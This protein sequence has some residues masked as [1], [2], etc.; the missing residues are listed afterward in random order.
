MNEESYPKNFIE[1]LD[2][3]K[4]EESCRKYLFEL[5]WKEGFH[6]PKCNNDT[7]WLTAQNLIHCK[8]CGHQ[9]SLTSGTIFHGTRKPLLL[10][11]HVMW[12]VV[13]QKTG[14]SA[15]NMTDLWGLE[16]IGQRGLGCKNYA[17]RWLG[18]AG[19]GCPGLLRL[20]KPSLEGWNPLQEIQE[21]AKRPK[22]WL[23]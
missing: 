22:H 9:T 1:F 4:D 15:S 14:I 3:F 12:W 13:A 5:K 11:F 17:G 7:Y 2:Q 8:D 21:E 18:R 19:T 10:W 16:A 20:M 6:C 23:S